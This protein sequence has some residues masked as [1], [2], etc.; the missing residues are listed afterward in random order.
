MAKPTQA[1]RWQMF[2]DSWAIR[3]MTAPSGERLAVIATRGITN[4][5]PKLQHWLRVL[6][7]AVVAAVAIAVM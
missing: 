5:S 3:L 1:K 7:L 6:V 4:G 2:F